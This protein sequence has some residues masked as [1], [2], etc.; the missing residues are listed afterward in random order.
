MV[1]TEYCPLGCLLLFLLYNKVSWEK[2][3][4]MMVSVTAGLAHLYSTSYYTSRGS[5]AEKYFVVHW[6][7]KSVNVLLT[8]MN[9]TCVLCDLG[10]ALVLDPT[11]DDMQ[12]ANSGQVCQS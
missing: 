8:N 3:L 9:E 12:L 4:N 6:D 5:L 1:V 11:V 10:L 2:T 7:V